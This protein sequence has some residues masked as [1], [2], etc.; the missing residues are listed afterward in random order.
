[1]KMIILENRILEGFSV[2]MMGCI[3]CK[4]SAIED[5]KDSPIDRTS[6]KASLDVRVLRATSSRREEAYREKDQCD[7]DDVRTMLIDKQVNV[8]VLLHCQIL[9]R[10]RE[11]QEFIASQQPRIGTVPKATEGEQV[12]ARWP[13][14]LAVVAGEAIRG[15]IPRRA[16]SFEKID[17]KKVVSLNK[18]RFDN[19]DQ[20]SVQFMAREIHILR[21]LDHPNVVKLEDL[22]TSRMSCS[23]YLVFEF[24]EHVLAGLALHSGLEFSESRVKCYMKQLLRGLDHCHGRGVLHWEG[25]NLLIDNNGILKIADF[26][27]A[28][29]YDPNQSQPFT[30]R[31]VTLWYRPPELLLGATCYGTAVD[32]WSTGCILA[33]LYAGKPIMPGR[34]EMH[35]NY[36]G[37]LR[38]SSCVKFSK[39]CGSPSEDYWRK[40]KLPNA[41]IFKPQQPYRPRVAEIF[42]EFTAPAL[43]LLETLLSVDPAGRGSAAS[44][45]KSDI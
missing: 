37:Y 13:A 10:K 12:A 5:S 8:S 27:L 32:L 9:D 16:D 21:R 35:N 33:E 25:P 19:H 17:K 7:N 43:A 24:M 34:T 23:L 22:V 31:V 6:S 28:S 38:W 1:M 45:L 4:P 20:E 44:A 29:F 42:Q 41:S 18:V 40:S 2:C 26:G 11:K 30:S 14:W 36:C 15:W 39:L 3:C